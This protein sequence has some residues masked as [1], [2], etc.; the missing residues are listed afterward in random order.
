MRLIVGLGN[1]GAK[2]RET[3]HNT[4][5]R[6][7]GQLA[8]RH[9]LSSEVRKFQGRFRRGRIAGVDVG[10]LKPETYMN[11]SGD[12]V[13][14][15]LRYLPVEAEDII[16]VVDDMDLP[17]GKLRI[18]PD[19]GHGGH[20]GI[21]S[22]IERLGTRE[23]TRVRVGVGRPPE[24]RAPTGHLLARVRE[25]DRERLEASVQRAVGA[26][27]V[28]LDKGVDEAMNRYNGHPSQGPKEAQED[29]E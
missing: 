24:G 13:A 25:D 21:R 11:L 12:S 7:C 9:E 22:V 18:R 15:A 3:P 27:E 10:V 17:C 4:G 6:V 5:F 2:Y 23:F 14:E 26:L 19:G 16:L 29:E 28:I 8:D 1:P 20:N